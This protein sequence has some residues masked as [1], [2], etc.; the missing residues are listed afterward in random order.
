[1]IKNKIFVTALAFVGL[2]SIYSC[3]KD[4]EEMWFDNQYV[5]L[6]QHHF[7]Q[8]EVLEGNSSHMFI[9]FPTYSFDSSTGILTDYG[10]N[11]EMNKSLQIILGTGSSA[12]GDALSGEGTML[13]GIEDIS[14]YHT[15]FII[16]NLDANG[17]VYFSYRDSVMVL[18]PNEEWLSTSSEI[19][20]ELDDNGEIGI[21]KYTYTNRITNWGKL[22]KE[23]FI[24]KDNIW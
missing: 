15:D 16:T 13:L 8:S 6:E 11:V 17:T 12:S 4:E 9:D 5:F 10:D 18:L 23:N 21:I 22:A 3:D 20:E 14:R 2:L 19:K 7:T 1:M 24:E